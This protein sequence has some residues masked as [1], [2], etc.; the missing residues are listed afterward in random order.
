MRWRGKCF[1]ASIRLEESR[2]HFAF[3]DFNQ[4][5]AKSL[6]IMTL[7]LLVIEQKSRCWPCLSIWASML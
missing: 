7:S 3:G 4:D 5:H 2:G 1:G 6:R